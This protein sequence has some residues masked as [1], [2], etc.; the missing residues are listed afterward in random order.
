[1][2]IH[3]LKVPPHLLKFAFL[4]FTVCYPYF[5]SGAVCKADASG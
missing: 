3:F 2:E 1:M 5:Y 4:S